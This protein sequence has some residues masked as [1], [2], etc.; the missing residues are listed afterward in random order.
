[1]IGVGQGVSSGGGNHATINND[2]GL[3]DTRLTQELFG[4]LGRVL[5]RR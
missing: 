4:F 2:L 1:M 5:K 3:A